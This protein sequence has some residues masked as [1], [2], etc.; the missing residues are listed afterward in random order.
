MSVLTFLQQN[1]VILDGGTG[2]LLQRAGLPLGELPERW[3]IT[4]AEV[5]QGV[6][7]DYFDAGSHIVCTNTFGANT[8]KFSQTELEEIIKAGVENA[9]IAAASSKGEQAKFVALDIGPLGKLLK[10]YGDLDFE[11]AVDIFAQTV[12]LGVKYGA[13]LLFIET[14]NDSLECKAA[15]LAAKENSDLP[16]F[17]SCAYGADGKLMTG[18]SPAAMVAMLEGMGADA[19]G[20]NCSVGPNQMQ[21]VVEELLEKASIPVLVKPN[22]G[23]PVAGKELAYDIDE[24]EFASLVAE[25]VKKGARLVGGCCGTTP[26]YI[27]AL[28]AE[29]DGVQPREIVKKNIT[30]V[31]SYTHAV[32]LD[33]PVLIGERINPTGK[34]RF[35]QALIDGDVGYVLN[36]GLVQQEKGAHILD[37]NV[38]AAEIDEKTQLVRYV[39]ELQAVVDLPLQIDT[40]DA[41]ALERAMRRYNGKPLV[42]S[43]NGKKESMDAV[44]PLVQKY[45]GVVV[46]LTLD[47]KGIPDSAE[48][49]VEIARKIIDEASKY[50]IAKKDIIVDT[51][52]MTISADKDAAQKT[53]TALRKVKEEFGVHTSLGVSNVSFGLPCRDVINANFFALALQNGLSAAIINPNSTEMLKTYYAYLALTGQDENCGQYIRF[54]E[55]LPA[56]TANAAQAVPQAPSADKRADTGAKTAL[57][58]AIVKGLK[59]KAGTECKALLSQKSALEIIE[60][61]IVPSLD[62]I[63]KAYEEKRAYLPQ[64]LMSAEAAKAAFEEIRIALLCKGEKT[65]KKGKI[66]LA[67]VKGD[68]HD[69]GKNIVATMLENYGFDVLDLGRDVAA[70]TV[71]KAVEESGA[72]LVGL[73]ALMTTTL[74]SMAETVALL[75]QKTPWVKIIVGGAVLTQAYADKIGADCYGKDAI[76][77]VRF[78]EKI[79]KN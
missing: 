32:E 75:K 74:P 22:A 30:C 46:A 42:N 15:L 58:D 62:E 57:Q 64:L 66:V 78:A 36:E 70:E 67:T 34:K 44:F 51:L 40:A 53:L 41:V 60:E 9:R 20:V 31:S 35:R 21:G 69:I 13:D 72:L 55:I 7:R 19:V 24:R 11:E 38:G 68:I 71:V 45:G 54:A 59:D 77:S 23:L 25:F 16:V 39:E 37:V 63:G 50:G 12:Q 61:Q 73:S 4:H 79:C 26:T 6:H 48:E 76:A 52:A 43:V 3:N 1:I 65:E 27:A 29:L 56:Q 8:L 28:K 49:R 2:T 14:M 10:P 47:E 33:K 18:A 17:V 5:L